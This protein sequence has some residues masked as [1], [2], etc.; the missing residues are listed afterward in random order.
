M[1]VC[2]DIREEV[3]QIFKGVIDVTPCHSIL[4]TDPFTTAR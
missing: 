3:F 2:N 4:N 1:D